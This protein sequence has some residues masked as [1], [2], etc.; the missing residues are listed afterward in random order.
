MT[1]IDISHSRPIAKS[2]AAQAGKLWVGLLT[3]LVVGSL[4]GSGAFAA[5]KQ[6]IIQRTPN[7]LR[8]RGVI[9]WRVARRRREC[10]KQTGTI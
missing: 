3:A 2:V 8:S 5:L 7:S 6:S 10:D 4:V 9:L 1:S